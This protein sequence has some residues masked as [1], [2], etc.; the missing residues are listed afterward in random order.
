MSAISHKYV[1]SEGSPS[2]KLW[3]V[4]EAPGWN[5]EQDGKPFIGESGKK[6]EEALGMAGV[7]RNEVFLTNLCHYRPAGNKF[8]ILLKSRELQEGVVELRE[9]L[10]SHRPNVVVALG[11]YPLEYLAGKHGITKYRGSILSCGSDHIGELGYEL[12]VIP[13]YHPAFVLRARQNFPIFVCDIQRA[14]N[15]SKF[16]EFNY[17]TRTI[18]IAPG[19]VA[20]SIGAKVTNLE[21][22][23]F[24]Y[25]YWLKRILSSGIVSCDIES[26]KKTTQILCVGFGISP[27]VGV[28]IP[29][30][31]TARH[32]E[33]I[34]AVLSSERVRKVCHFGTYDVTVLRENGHTV[35]AYTDDTIIQAHVLA[36]ELPRDLAYLVSVHTREPYFKEEGRAS[37]PGDVKGWSAKRNKQD[38]Y[39]YNGRDITTTIELYHAQA[40]EISED[41]DHSSIYAYEMEMQQVALDLGMTG[42]ER[43]LERVEAIKKAVERK[44]ALYWFFIERLSGIPIRNSANKEVCK[45]LYK[46]FKL[47]ERKKTNRKSGKVTVTSDEDAL[48]SLITFCKTHINKLKSNKALT[49]WHTKL[50]VVELLLKVR[51]QEKILSSYINISDHNGRVLGLYKVAGTETG[52][53]SASQYV[54][55]S[56]LNIQTIPR[57]S[58]SDDP[59]D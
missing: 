6:L 44:L 23:P 47:P 35:Q 20:T 25:D 9:L 18:H 11:A 14:V 24:D 30:D 57:S 46:H 56:G 4:G 58:V 43:D 29:Y 51:E 42:L 53:W 16:P 55:G 1:T 36:P 59:N 21:S 8:E 17:P 50:K 10:N 22:V 19:T 37:I 2:S 3:L 49:E 32:Y 15:D 48:V 54:D 41:P 52:R 7:S 26:V 39:I 13:S 34:D 5:E 28:V 40:T 27:D 38:L 45:L 31:G 33:F 12:K